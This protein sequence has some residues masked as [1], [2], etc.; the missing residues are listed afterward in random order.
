MNNIIIE[1]TTQ[2]KY[3]YAYEAKQHTETTWVV[4]KPLVKFGWQSV[5]FAEP[6]HTTFPKFNHLFTLEET[7]R[8][9]LDFIFVDADFAVG[10][11]FHEVNI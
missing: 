4:L 8:G 1:I 3:L 2:N 10:S 11:Y 6:G 5:V 7:K 9:I